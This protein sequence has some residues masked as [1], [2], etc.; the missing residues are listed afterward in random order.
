LNWIT[1]SDSRTRAVPNCQWTGTLSI[2]GDQS[3]SRLSGGAFGSLAES[4]SSHASRPKC[5]PNVPT[6]PSACTTAHTQRHDPTLTTHSC[7]AYAEWHLCAC[8]C[9]Q[10]HVGDGRNRVVG[11][12]SAHHGLQR[13]HLDKYGMCCSIDLYLFRMLELLGGSEAAVTMTCLRRSQQRYSSVRDTLAWNA[14]S[15]FASINYYFL[16]LAYFCA[17]DQN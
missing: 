13:P 14:S 5:E 4:S 15:C 11:E 9:E 8:L 12:G 16:L 1:V 17:C 2:Y 7:N 3:T 6:K 10:E